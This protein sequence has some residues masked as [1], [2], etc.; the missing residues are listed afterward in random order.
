MSD[1]LVVRCFDNTDKII[2]TQHY[3]LSHDLTTERSHFLVNLF[4]VVRVFVQRLPALR[5]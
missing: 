5:G 1:S 3:I 4:Q 2:S